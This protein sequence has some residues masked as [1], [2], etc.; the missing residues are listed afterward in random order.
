MIMTS[1]DDFTQALINGTRVL[2]KQLLH[3]FEDAVADTKEFL[4]KRGKDLRRWTQLL[5][6][7]QLTQQEFVDLLEA[8]KDLFELHLLRQRVVLLAKL[9]RFRKGLLDLVVNTAFN[10]FLPVPH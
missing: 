7:K 10:V 2:A 5:A 6:R 1:F 8:Q 3:E 4:E 9:E